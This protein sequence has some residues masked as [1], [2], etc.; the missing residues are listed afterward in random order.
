MHTQLLMKYFKCDDEY[1]I[2]KILMYANTIT[3]KQPQTIT[4]LTVQ[5]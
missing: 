3:H 4:C 1:L 5:I 2:N